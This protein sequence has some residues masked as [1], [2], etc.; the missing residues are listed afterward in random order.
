MCA[1]ACVFC[2]WVFVCDS[3]FFASGRPSRTPTLASRCPLF[4][5]SFAGSLCLFVCPIN[6]GSGLAGMNGGPNQGGGLFSEGTRGGA[7]PSVILPTRPPSSPQTPLEAPSVL[8]SATVLCSFR[9]LASLCRATELS[10]SS[11]LACEYAYVS[12]GNSFELNRSIKIW[13]DWLTRDTSLYTGKDPNKSRR[14]DKGRGTG[15]GEEPSRPHH[16]TNRH[17]AL[18]PPPPAP[19]AAPARF[20]LAA[21]SHLDILYV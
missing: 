3:S 10:A 20:S 6:T 2:F 8:G 19:P 21:A 14:G 7:C 9:F 5:Q 16:P 1:C 17:A 12:G 13:F 4:K 11:P 18:F 15:Q